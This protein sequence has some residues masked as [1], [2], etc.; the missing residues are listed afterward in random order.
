MFIRFNERERYLEVVGVES[1]CLGIL[2][3]E[4]GIRRA[5]EDLEIADQGTCLVATVFRDVLLL[6]LSVVGLVFR[7]R[8]M[9]VQYVREFL[10]I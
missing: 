7:S 3:S 4:N 2:P 1:I 9:D 6:T 8:K 10:T 5:C